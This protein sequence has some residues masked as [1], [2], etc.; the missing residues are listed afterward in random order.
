MDDGTNEYL[1]RGGLRK[2]NRL[3]DSTYGRP[4]LATT[5]YEYI[6]F[7]FVVVMMQQLLE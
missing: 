7:C 5:S 3:P 1:P 6:V 2:I 4:R